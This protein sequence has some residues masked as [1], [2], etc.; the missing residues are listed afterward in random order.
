MIVIT[1]HLS[2]GALTSM[3]LGSRFALIVFYFKR[4]QLTQHIFVA[5]FNFPF[6]GLSSPIAVYSFINSF[7]VSASDASSSIW[8][9]KLSDK[10]GTYSYSSNR[11]EAFK[12]KAR[13]QSFPKYTS[14]Q[15]SSSNSSG[16]RIVFQFLSISENCLFEI[17]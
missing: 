7:S 5:S 9:K 16:S 13:S 14:N 4:F 2:L 8:N 15:I 6:K 10:Q 3:C 12:I 17:I 11:L 1:A